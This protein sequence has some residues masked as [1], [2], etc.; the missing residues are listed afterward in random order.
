[1]LDCLC[2]SNNLEVLTHLTEKRTLTE[3][4]YVQR[5][6]YNCVGTDMYRIQ[7]ERRNPERPLRTVFQNHSYPKRR[8]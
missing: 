6:R 4:I 5:P 2:T 3:D 1:M 8:P 7:T